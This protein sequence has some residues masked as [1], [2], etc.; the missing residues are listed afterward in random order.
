[1]RPWAYLWQ[2]HVVAGGRDV[3]EVAIRLL[4]SS[5][6]SPVHACSVACYDNCAGPTPT[7]GAAQSLH[8]ILLDSADWYNR[9]RKR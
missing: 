3:R 6:L 7:G 1:M 2:L 5:K 8:R 4:R 9:Q